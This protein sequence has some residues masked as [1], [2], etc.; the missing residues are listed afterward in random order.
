MKG[1]VGWERDRSGWRVTG[2][3]VQTYIRSVSVNDEA[4]E[5]YKKKSSA[6]ESHG[7]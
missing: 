7:H 2:Q 6:N 4:K 3:H 1:V 5:N